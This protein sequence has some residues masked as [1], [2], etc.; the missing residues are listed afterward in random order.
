MIALAV[1]VCAY[2][3]RWLYSSARVSD[4]LSHDC[5]AFVGFSFRCHI[6]K[7]KQIISPSTQ[8]IG[9]KPQTVSGLLWVIIHS[10]VVLT[11]VMVSCAFQNSDLCSPALPYGLQPQ[12][13]LGAGYLLGGGASKGHLYLFPSYQPPTPR[14]T[15]RVAVVSLLY[16][17]GGPNA[18]GVG[19]RGVGGWGRDR[20][21]FICSPGVLR[22][23]W[24]IT[25][26]FKVY[27]ILVSYICMLQNDY[28]CGI[29]LHLHR[30]T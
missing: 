22:Y 3:T 8:I 27:N 19:V 23:D 11:L 26:K 18:W 21:L 4:Q 6:R 30:V 16:L 28:Y 29:R 13:K 12:G 14:L 15:F 20:P 17:S 24:P 7:Q 2:G 9:E 25:C 10:A 5:S 1:S